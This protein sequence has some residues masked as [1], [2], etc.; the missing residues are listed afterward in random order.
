MNSAQQDQEH[1]LEV[2]FMLS[3]HNMKSLL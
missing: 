2:M 3:R 1:L